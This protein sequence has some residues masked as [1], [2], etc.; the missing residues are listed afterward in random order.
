M[1]PRETL[2][3]YLTIVAR[4]SGQALSPDCG[5]PNLI[6][7]VTPLRKLPL[8]DK[9]MEFQLIDRDEKAGTENEAMNGPIVYIWNVPQ[10]LVTGWVLL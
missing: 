8:L 9:S 2:V 5:F 10:R 6:F 3:G 7:L 1:T 4:V